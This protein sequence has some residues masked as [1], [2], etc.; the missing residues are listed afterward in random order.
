M[1][2]L[3]ELDQNEMQDAGTFGRNSEVIGIDFSS[4]TFSVPGSRP[5]E[6][7]EPLCIG[8]NFTPSGVSVSG[9]VVHARTSYECLISKSPG[10]QE[11]DIVAR[12]ACVLDATYQLQESYRPSHSEL[13]AFHKANVVFNCWPFF[14]EFVQTSAARMNV[15]P[16]PIPFIRVQTKRSDQPRTTRKGLVKRTK[17]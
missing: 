8:I 15:P 17:I 14:R 1:P 16:P 3:I 9:D 13:S 2:I 5:Q 11:S 10:D 7:Q 4:G 6:I 12:F